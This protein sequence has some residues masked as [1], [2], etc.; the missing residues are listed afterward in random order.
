MTRYSPPQPKPGLPLSIHVGFATHAQGDKS[1][2]KLTGS[3]R[4]FD[5]PVRITQIIEGG[6][7]DRHPDLRFLAVETDSSWL[8]YLREQMDDRFRRANPAT[9]APIQRRPGDYF[10][11]NIASTFI[12]DRYGII[13]RHHIGVTQM[14]WSSDFPHGG[15]DW[16]NSRTT[17]KD[18]FDGVPDDERHAI[19]AGNV[20]RIYGHGAAS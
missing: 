10:D 19:L 1:K 13:N 4:F 14:M 20:L 16:P 7:F 17:I 5:M 2:M 15:S 18:H 12:T 8:P 3:M 9:R 6:V 11:T